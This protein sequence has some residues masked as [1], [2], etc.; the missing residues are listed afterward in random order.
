MVSL[1][2]NFQF[3]KSNN[4]WISNI[5]LELRIHQHPFQNWHLNHDLPEGLT[6][7][8]LGARRF[9]SENG[10]N[11]GFSEIFFD[12]FWF[13]DFFDLIWT[14]FV[15]KI[16]FFSCFLG[17][18]TFFRPNFLDF[19][20]FVL[21]FWHR[22]FWVYEIFVEWT[23]PRIYPPKSGKY[24]IGTEQNWIEIL[25]WSHAL[26]CVQF[27]V[28]IKHSRYYFFLYRRFLYWF[29]VTSA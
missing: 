2:F 17:F 29:N 20:K 5:D 23:T 7:L 28:T 21:D 4:W 1:F 22:F 3:K 9:K 16:G 19:F 14:F 11:S 24:T 27:P 12:F 8:H 13:F 18:W 6:T 25:D 26:T 10:K 15:K